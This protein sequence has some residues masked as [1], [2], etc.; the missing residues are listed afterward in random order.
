MGASVAR[1][2]RYCGRGA[3]GGLRVAEIAITP[4]TDVLTLCLKCG[5]EYLKKSRVQKWCPDCG[6]AKRRA[7][8]SKKR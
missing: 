3:S 5:R 8:R 4:A 1:F 7:A 6:A 2:T